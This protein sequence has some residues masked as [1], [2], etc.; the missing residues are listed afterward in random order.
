[1]YYP[2]WPEYVVVVLWPLHL[3][4]VILIDLLPD[5]THT[6]VLVMLAL[7]TTARSHTHKLCVYVWRRANICL[8]STSSS[9][10]VVFVFLF[11][12]LLTLPSRSLSL[13]ALS[14]SKGLT[15]SASVRCLSRAVTD[16][17]VH[18]CRGWT[19][20]RELGALKREQ[21]THM[22]PFLLPLRRCPPL[23][24][25]FH[26]RKCVYIFYNLSLHLCQSIP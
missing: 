10:P 23:L 12:G 8:I 6:P 25:G 26:Q 14:P 15:H 3:L 9:H 7:S 1:M 21:I 18:W 16:G 4:G 13:C 17:R 22:V 19:S 2:S 24:F 11:S 20:T 5:H